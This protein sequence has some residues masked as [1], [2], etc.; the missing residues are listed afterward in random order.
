MDRTALVLSVAVT[1]LRAQPLPPGS[2]SAP[3]NV[4]CPSGFYAGMTCKVAT[5]SCPATDDIQVTFGVK[6][7]NNLKGTI[8]LLSGSGGTQ[9]FGQ[10]GN[11]FYVDEYYRAKF[12]VVQVAW[13]SDW[14]QATASGAQSI[15]AAACRPSTL[16]RYIYDSIHGGIAASGGMCAHGQSG[17]SGALAYALAWYDA[18]NYLDKALLTSG[19]V[20][21]DI[22]QGCKVPNSSQIAVCPA[23][24][25]GCIGASWSASPVYIHG[26]GMASWTGDASCNSGADTSAESNAAWKAQSI[27]DGTSGPSFSYP[28]TA[29][30]AYLCA[31]TAP[32]SAQGQYFYQQFTG[33]S[34]AAAYSVNRVNGCTQNENIW[35]GTI[36]GGAS[37]YT[38]S[39]NG[40]VQG[41]IKRH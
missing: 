41:C 11:S 23:G 28:Q 17:G 25:F 5:V 6:T 10:A 38:T 15:K 13:A 22:E 29:L 30:S 18:G 8:V 16:I 32:A 20:F 12:R 19:P 1:I 2:V 4:T 31:N 9:P 35:T 34:Q 14:E 40:M 33:S 21:G 27:V 26:D 39:V 37:A 36:A 3:A 24:Q 7:P